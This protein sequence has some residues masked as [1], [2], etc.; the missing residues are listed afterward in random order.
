MTTSTPTR[1]RTTERTTERT[2][3]REDA[4]PTTETNLRARK[5]VADADGMAVASFI[6][7]LIGLLAFNLLLGP[8]A[9][10]L[11]GLALARGTKRRGRAWL[12]SALGAA[13]LII[14]AVLV[15]ADHTISWSLGG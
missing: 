3:Q 6:L 10:V 2:A 14:L 15:T 4:G 11:A 8:S 7:G 12:G 13:D 9:L 1:P 5:R